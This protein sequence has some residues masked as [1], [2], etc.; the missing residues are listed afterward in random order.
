MKTSVES[1]SIRK[2]DEEVE[3]SIPEWT[4]KADYIETCNCDYGCPCN[5]NGFPSNGFCSALVG[6]HIR[7]G[8]YGS[9]KLDDLDVVD[10]YSWPKAIHEGNGT[11]QIFITNKAREQEQKDAIIKIFTGKAKGNGHFEL[12]ATTIKYQLDP[13]F[14]DIHMNVNGRK[15]SFT[16]PGVIDVKLENFVNPVTGGE[17]DTKIQ[18]PKGFIWKLADAAKTKIMSISTSSLNFNH[19]G[20]NAFYSIVEFQGP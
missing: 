4:L 16:V 14:V 11:H 19:S 17:Q 6:Y 18:L 8:N 13:Q 3:K 2:N 7:Q 15:S 12:F 5:F 1:P 20:K 9:V 10:V